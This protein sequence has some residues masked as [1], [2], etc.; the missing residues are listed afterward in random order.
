MLEDSAIWL[1]TEGAVEW[2]ADF[3]KSHPSVMPF[4]PPPDNNQQPQQQED[5]DSTVAADAVEGEAK[6]VEGEDVCG[7]EGA[8]GEDDGDAAAEDEDEEGV[9]ILSPEE[10][11]EMYVGMYHTAIEM[12]EAGV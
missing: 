4:P 2:L 6:S 7:E 11:L 12:V 5:E 1:E 9:E 8:A 10:A 3:A